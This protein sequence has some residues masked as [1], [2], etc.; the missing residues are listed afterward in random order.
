LIRLRWFPRIEISS[1]EEKSTMRSN[2]AMRLSV[3]A[4]VIAATAV[5]SMPAKSEDKS[6]AVYKQKCA[7]CH[8]PDGKG[9]T[10]VGKSA[11]VRSFGDPDVGKQ[12]DDELASVIEKG[13]NKMPAYGKSLKPEEIKAL[14][15][16]IRTLAK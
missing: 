14:V 11:K 4:A 15:A 16:Y 6:A 10:P 3:L 8:G 7:A 12:S 9:D 5:L 2:W 1:E 13:K